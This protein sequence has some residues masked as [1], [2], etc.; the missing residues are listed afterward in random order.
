MIPRKVALYL[1]LEL[2]SVSTAASS[3]HCPSNCRETEVIVGC[4]VLQVRIDI[5]EFLSCI[6]SET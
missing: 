4:E 5:D 6:F 1:P 3:I 2:A